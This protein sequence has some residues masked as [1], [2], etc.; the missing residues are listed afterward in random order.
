MEN[1]I[2]AIFQL[3]SVI[4]TMEQNLKRYAL[5]PQA[6]I[7]YIDSQNKIIAQLYDIYNSIMILRY[8]NIW[9]EVE[10]I[11]LQI[12]QKSPEITE[13]H[14]HLTTKPEKGHFS[15]ILINPFK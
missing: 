7:G 12:E 6:K 15:R 3:Q 4:E 5:Q 14:I 9:L 10:A 8:Y 11:I 13:H 1:S 2:D